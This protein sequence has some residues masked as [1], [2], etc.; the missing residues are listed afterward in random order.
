[1]KNDFVNAIFG[2]STAAPITAYFSNGTSAEYTA[3]IFNLLI[4]DP[5]TEMIV[6][7]A[8]CEIIWSR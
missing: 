2:K 3:D 8:T 5:D 4:T 7:P 1:M 6:D